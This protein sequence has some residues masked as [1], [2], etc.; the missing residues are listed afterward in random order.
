M[1]FILHLEYIQGL[2]NILEEDLY[3]G[4]VMILSNATVDDIFINMKLIFRD[5][6]HNILILHKSN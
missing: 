4:E 1:L 6:N 5:I 3:Y 2:P